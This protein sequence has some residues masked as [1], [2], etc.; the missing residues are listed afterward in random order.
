MEDNERGF[1]LSTLIGKLV[2]KCL[3]IVAILAAAKIVLEKVFHKTICFSVA[4]DDVS[5]D[6]AENEDEAD[7]EEEEE[8]PEESPEEEKTEEN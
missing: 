1:S 2:L 4:V 3:A 5:N 7:D 8:T 6:E